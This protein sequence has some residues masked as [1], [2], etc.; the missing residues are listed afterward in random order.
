M[1]IFFWHQFIFD[2][3]YFLSLSVSSLW[4]V[5]PQRQ[6]VPRDHLFNARLQAEISQQLLPPTWQPWVRQYKQDI[7]FLWWVQTQI[8]HQAVEDI[9][10]LFQLFTNRCPSGRHDILHARRVV[11]R[12]VYRWST[13]SHKSS[14]RHSGSWPGVRSTMGRS[15]WCEFM[16][17]EHINVPG[18]QIEKCIRFLLDQRFI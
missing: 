2:P 11:T 15:W 14:F 18:L 12:P 3:L 17:T 5:Q 9:Y 13:P 10:G 8:Q 7:R 16:N 4:L 6:T 1:L